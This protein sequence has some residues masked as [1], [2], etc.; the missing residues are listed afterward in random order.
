M[1]NITDKKTIRN[2]KH[3]KKSYLLLTFS[4][5]VSRCRKP[6]QH[7]YNPPHRAS[8]I[9]TP[10]ETWCNN[11]NKPNSIF[12]SEHCPRCGR[13]STQTRPHLL[14]DATVSRPRFA[15]AS[16]QIRSCLL[17]DSLK[18]KGLELRRV[19][20]STSTDVARER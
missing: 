7:L 14:P 17:P 10:S 13:I 2:L 1:E 20:R 11:P 19:M 12:V 5:G 16:S 9:A 18:N 8:N 15:R 4:K 3:N 6:G